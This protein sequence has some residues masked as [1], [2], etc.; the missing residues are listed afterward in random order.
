MNF[1][2]QNQTKAGYSV[3]FAAF[4]HLFFPAR[5]KESQLQ[6]LLILIAVKKPTLDLFWLART[7]IVLR[8][9]EKDKLK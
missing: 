3:S 9:L 1:S 2:R 6:F 4:A 7:K 8:I 5:H